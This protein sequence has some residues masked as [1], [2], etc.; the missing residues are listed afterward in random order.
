MGAELHGADGRSPT[1]VASALKDPNSASLQRLQ[2]VK[3]WIEKGETYEQVYD[4]ACSDGGW[5]AGN[6][7][8][9]R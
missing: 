1:F 3:G 5:S 2:I 4:V 9:P 8:V 7:S 6:S